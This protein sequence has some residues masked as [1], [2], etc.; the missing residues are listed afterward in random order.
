MGPDDSGNDLQ[1][2]TKGKSLFSVLIDAG[3]NRLLALVLHGQGHENDSALR[4]V[5]IQGG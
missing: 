3:V 2:L 1:K 5:G 4:I